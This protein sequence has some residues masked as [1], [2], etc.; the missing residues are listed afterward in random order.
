MTV[1]K[2]VHRIGGDPTASLHEQD[3]VSVFSYA[4]GAVPEGSALAAADE[5]K[6]SDPFPSLG[7]GFGSSVVLFREG[8]IAEEIAKSPESHEL[9][10]LN[11][12]AA[13]SDLEAAVAEAVDGLAHRG[14]ADYI[15]L[16][17]ERGV[18]G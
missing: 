5:E 10:T 12:E 15:V 13:G 8:A 11:V 9:R 18:D 3:G 17:R 16:I 1:V 6:G 2:E 4:P 14:D 7:G